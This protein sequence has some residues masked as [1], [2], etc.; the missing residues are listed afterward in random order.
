LSRE[1]RKLEILVEETVGMLKIAKGDAA[2]NKTSV[3]EWFSLFKY[4]EMSLKDQ[5]RSRQPSMSKI[6]NDVNDINTLVHENRI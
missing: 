6:D 1:T 4:R 2:L 5:F 3:Y